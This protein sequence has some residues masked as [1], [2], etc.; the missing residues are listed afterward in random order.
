MVIF[1]KKKNPKKPQQQLLEMVMQELCL[2][3]EFEFLCDF[4]C[5][6]TA[7]FLFFSLSQWLLVTA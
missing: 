6:Y 5:P 4:K 2:G 3:H 1:H 7:T